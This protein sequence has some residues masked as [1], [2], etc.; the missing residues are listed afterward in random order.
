MSEYVGVLSV[1]DQDGLVLAGDHLPATWM[2]VDPRT[3]ILARWM[4]GPSDAAVNEALN[5]A[6]A[7]GGWREDAAFTV[8]DRQL[9][10]FDSAEAGAEPLGP[11]LTVQL[12]PGTYVV[13]TCEYRPDPEISLV[14]HRLRG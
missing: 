10:L 3:G 11:R 9:Y 8:I 13:E 4:F 1:G 14:L 7:L 2:S 5:H 6:A 12:D